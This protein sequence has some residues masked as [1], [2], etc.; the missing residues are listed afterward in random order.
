[1]QSHFASPERARGDVLAKDIRFVSDNPVITGLLQSV[2]GLLAVLNEQRQILA[3]NE[4]LLQSL[5]ISESAAILGLR[6]GEALNCI[7]PIESPG[8]CG[9]TLHCS[10]CGAAIAIVTSL[11]TDQPVE[12][13]CAMQVERVGEHRD[14]YLRVRSVPIHY[15]GHDLL[16]LFLQDI[17]YLQ[18][19]SALERL[20]YHDVNNIIHGLLSAS[21]LLDDELQ[22]GPDG[23]SRIVSRLSS[24]LGQ[25]VAMQRALS[26][27]DGRGYQPVF[28]LVPLSQLLQEI[29]DQFAHH[30]LLNGKTLVMPSTVPHMSIRTDMTLLL[31]IVGNMLINALEA[32]DAGGEVRFSVEH[33]GSFVILSVWNRES[34]PADVARRV[35]QRNFSTK[36]D[37]GRG[38][39]TY[40]MKLFGEEILGGKVGFTS[41]E[42]EGTRFSFILPR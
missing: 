13:S 15:E 29:S 30:E 39:G 34:I 28:D 14:L 18:R 35:F 37:T 2:S 8:G 23:L 1:M 9:T 25:E 12:R 41:T 19:L 5:G 40:S 21:K 38:L 26:S 17:T 6:P 32:T 33:N 4:A 24:R 16:L 22:G 7:H 20:F 10:T 27:A 11:T 31:R 3:V 42:Q 36:S